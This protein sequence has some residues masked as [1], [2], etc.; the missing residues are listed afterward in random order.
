MSCPKKLHIVYATDQCYLF[1]TQV[2][3]SSAIACSSRRSYICI[4]ILDCGVPDEE[5]DCFVRELR[6]RLGNEFGLVRHK[7]DMRRYDEYPSWHG[8]KGLYARLELP[9]ILSDI[10]WCVY[11]DGDTLFT[12]DPLKLADLCSNEYALLGH[13]DDFDDKQ[14]KWHE[15]H[16]LP[17][18]CRRR[19]C[20][21]F[22]LMNL[23]WFRANDGSKRCLRFVESYPDVVFPDQDA[24]NYVC[25]G[26]I[27]LL[28]DEWGKITYLANAQTQRGCFHY[29]AAR[30]WEMN[31]KGRLPLDS[32]Q[33]IWFCSVCQMFGLFPWRC[34]KSI[35]KYIYLYLKTLVWSGIYKMVN[36]IPCIK[37]RYDG[38]YNRMWPRSKERGFIS[39]G[40]R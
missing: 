24:L 5:W 33:R 11:A 7:I 9:I 21:G 4:D 3:A 35:L 28:P 8:S 29:V 23:K 39:G 36:R 18:D 13:E 32:L 6:E 38:V 31:Q 15:D 22:L 2:A 40:N 37:G 16:E 12:D 27:G 19:I 25:I 34:N 20:S 14:K 17:F 26:K 10:D 1:P 30:P